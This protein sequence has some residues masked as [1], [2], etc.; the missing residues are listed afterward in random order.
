[1][2]RIRSKFA[3]PLA[4]AMLAMAPTA[5]LAEDLIVAAVSGPR[6]V[7]GDVWKPGSI[8]S[9]VNVYESLVRYGF[10]PAEN[11]MQVIDS[12]VIE[13]HLAESW[14]VSEDGTEY[15][16]TLRQGVKS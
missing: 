11:G 1:M 13:P 2:T 12:S 6:G 4:L 7:D 8:E 16:F 14:T 9:V 5:A 15:V 10:K 3:V